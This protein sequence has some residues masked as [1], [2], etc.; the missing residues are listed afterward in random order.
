MMLNQ[1]K[2]NH[3]LYRTYFFIKKSHTWKKLE[4]NIKMLMIF[5]TNKSNL[6]IYVLILYVFN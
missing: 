2:L 4:E 3:S 6:L 1:V 5:L